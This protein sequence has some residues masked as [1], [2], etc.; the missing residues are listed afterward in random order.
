MNLPV[1][2]AA[3]NEELQIGRN[4]DVLSRQLQRVEPI[5]VVNG[6]TDRTA[7]IARQAG[8]TVLESPE[9]KMPALQ[10]GLRYLGKRA[11]NSLLILDADS[12]PFT[13]KWSRHMGNEL[14]SSLERNPAMVW[15]AYVYNEEINPLL[16]VFFTGTTMRVAW[17][18]RHKERPRTV[19]GGNAGLFIKKSK[20]L[21]EMLAL[22]NYWP[23]EDVAIFDTMK[24]HAAEHKVTLRPDAW[25][26]TSG[27]RITQTLKRIVRERKHPSLVMDDT[28]ARE[29]PLDSKPYN[30]A[31][32]STVKH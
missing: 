24:S 5:V 27:Y 4:L 13:K 28:Y 30:S 14:G 19:R 32:T 6:S 7:D 29:A 3:R 25:V 22:E 11:L 18:D 26:L 8:A 15:G 23:R 10:E 21:E 17:A 2:I 1:I 12:R 9:G 20:L 31:T 16:A